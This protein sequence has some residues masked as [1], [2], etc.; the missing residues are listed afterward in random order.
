MQ[1]EPLLAVHLFACC[2]LAGSWRQLAGVDRTRD[3][4]GLCLHPEEAV[5][6][7]RLYSNAHVIYMY[8]N[9][10]TATAMAHLALLFG[11]LP[12]FVNQVIY[13]ITL[14]CSFNQAGSAFLGLSVMYDEHST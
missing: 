14:T 7:S 13:T 6:D 5:R 4:R 9:P 8:Q 10:A 2:V 3:E 12:A 1:V 11:D